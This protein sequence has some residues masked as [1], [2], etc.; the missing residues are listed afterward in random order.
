MLGKLRQVTV[1][2]IFYH[3]HDIVT[4]TIA[5]NLRHLERNHPQ[6]LDILAVEVE[7]VHDER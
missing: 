5:W 3:E 6:V 2:W 7:T 1:C 4:G